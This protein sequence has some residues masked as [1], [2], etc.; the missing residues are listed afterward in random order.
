MRIY[1]PSYFALAG[2]GLG[3]VPVDAS[4]SVDLADR[5]VAQR[6][7]VAPAGQAKNLAATVAVVSLRKLQKRKRICLI[8]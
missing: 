6:R 8:S 2:K 4:P 5:D 7:L 1:S 3:T